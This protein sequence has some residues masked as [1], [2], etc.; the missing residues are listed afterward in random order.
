[1]ERKLEGHLGNV[2]CIKFFNKLN[3][4]ISGSEDKMLKVWD[5][6]SDFACVKTVY[7]HQSWINSISISKDDLR[8]ISGSLDKTIKVWDLK[9]FLCMHTI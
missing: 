2:W 8:L 4:L 5:F 7:G 6:D 1:M 3:M 9:N